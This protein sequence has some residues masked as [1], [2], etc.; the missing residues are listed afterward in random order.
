[1]IESKELSREVI[2]QRAYEL[3][4]ERGGEAGRDVEDWVRAE[5]ELAAK[6]ILTPTTAKAARAGQTN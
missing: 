2:A 6:P 4:I 3:Y 5:K 1:M